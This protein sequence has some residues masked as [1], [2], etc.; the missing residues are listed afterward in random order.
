METAYFLFHVNQHLS[1]IK[2]EYVAE[3]F[4]L[5]ELILIPDSPLN[6][7]GLLDLR[8]EVLPVLDFQ[9]GP[10]SRAESGAESDAESDAE[11][12]SGAQPKK[13]RLTDS[14]IVLSQDQLKIGLVVN[15]VQGM[16]ELSSQDIT[17]EI[18]DLQAGISPAL[19]KIVS[20]T[21]ADED[22]NEGPILVF[23]EP[24]AWFSGGEIQQF[25]SVTSF[26]INDSRNDP[27]G[28]LLQSEKQPS[29]PL[30]NPG[31]LASEDSFCP[32]ATPEERIRFRQRADNLK[33]SLD[34]DQP[35]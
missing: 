11:S 7:V 6:I 1:A 17:S 9:S 8:G 24:N 25:I 35:I 26:L 13:Y 19:A 31:G 5:P 18:A 16:R 30:S 29:N 4:A 12:G 20:G 34:A 23:N 3:V 14:I 22:A 32:T 2:A 15:A 28:R 27:D 10:E 33:R 21:I